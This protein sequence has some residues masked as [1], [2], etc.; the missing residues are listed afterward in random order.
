MKFSKIFFWL[1]ASG[2][3]LLANQCA[4]IVNPNGGKKDTKPPHAI[5]Y[6]PD[7][8]KTNFTGNKIEIDFNELI[9]LNDLQKQLVVSPPLIFQPEV[10]VKG[11]SL[12]IELKDTLKE[13][14]TYT[15]NFGDAIRDITE[16]NPIDN[17]QYICSTGNYIDSLSLSGTVKNAFE[18]KTE[19]R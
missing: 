3:W 14:T 4:Q 7:S 18:L 9:Q 19:K 10:K 13:N 8:A 5:K 1:L 6:F 11:K 15:F 12:L 16:N 2:F 17:F